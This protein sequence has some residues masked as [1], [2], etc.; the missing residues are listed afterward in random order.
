MV[1][2][3]VRVG[4]RPVVVVV[5]NGVPVYEKVVMLGAVEI[6]TVAVVLKVLQ[7]PAAGTE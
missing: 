5:Q 2:D 7:P 4:V 6:D 1:D 3:A